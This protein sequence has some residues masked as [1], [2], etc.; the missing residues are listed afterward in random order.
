MTGRVVA[1]AVLTLA[2]LASAANAEMLLPPGFRVEVYVTGDGFDT[3]E[4]RV[5]QGIPSASTLAVDHA[6]TLYLARPGRRY[7]GGEVDDIW[8]VYRFP[9]G[10]G[11]AT[12][13]TE[14][15]YLYGPPLPSA[16]IAGVRAG[17]ELLVTTFDRDRKVGV[18]YVMVNGSAELFAGG[19]P[20]R[21]ATPV[22]VQPE[23]AAADAAG[24]IYVADRAEDRVVKF[25]PRGALLDASHVKLQRPRALAIGGDGA[26]WIA[27]DGSAEAPW[28]RGPGEI[29]RV[30][31]DA[32]PALL[33][34][35]PVA[36]GM[37]LSATGHLFIA[38]RQA[39]EIFALAPDGRV[40]SFARFTD[41]DA[42][43]SLT[44]V[45][46]TPETERAGIAGSLLVVAIGKGAWPV[47]EVLKISGPFE[48]FLREATP[49]AR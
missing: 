10:G 40:T 17:R 13:K 16:Q 7:T 38:D 42:P 28:Q 36:A 46:V 5:A 6:G 41:G 24:N 8:P 15:R 47:N 31:G 45:P 11:R 35:G 1:L 4:G 26:L 14:A 20:P 37:A 18:L 44:F 19:T 23:G 2:A 21:G 29:W 30:A 39:P 32:A 49:A 27:S 33:R 12:K 43:R 22:L 34:R 48:R 25:D 3:V 9:A